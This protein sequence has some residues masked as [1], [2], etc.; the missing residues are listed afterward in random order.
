MEAQQFCFSCGA[1]LA[2]PEMKGTHENYCK[3]CKD[4]AGNTPAKEVIQGGIAEWFMSWQTEI[5]KE[6]AFER[7][8][9]YMKAMPH[10]A[11]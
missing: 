11:E 2:M 6:Q 1:P 5:T 9:H 4:E 3:F 8:G 7:A 10:W